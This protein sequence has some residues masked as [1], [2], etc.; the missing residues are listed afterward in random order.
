MKNIKG[1]LGFLFSLPTKETWCLLYIG[2]PGQFA[3]S[4]SFARK[5]NVPPERQ[6]QPQEEVIY[7]LNHLPQR[8]KTQMLR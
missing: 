7:I 4:V 2:V 8:Y 1:I 5:I 3:W 6:P